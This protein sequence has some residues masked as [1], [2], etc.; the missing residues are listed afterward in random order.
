M[1]AQS[2][3]IGFS[4]TTPE[5]VNKKPA[6]EIRLNLGRCRR[7]NTSYVVLTLLPDRWRCQFFFEYGQHIIDTA[8]PVFLTHIAG[9]LGPEVLTY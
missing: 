9:E 4:H 3:I 8:E 1:A 7:N 6:E 2:R 5:V